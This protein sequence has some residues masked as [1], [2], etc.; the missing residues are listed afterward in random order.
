M[1]FKRGV[2]EEIEQVD[3]PLSIGTPKRVGKRKP[4]ANH[5][6]LLVT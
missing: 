6:T 5:A 4:H 2:L 3:M 1:L